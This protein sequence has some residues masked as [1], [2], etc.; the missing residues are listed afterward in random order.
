M[1]SASL[2]V[3]N[4]AFRREDVA[5]P[6]DGFGFLVPH[7]EPEFP[8]MG[9]LFADSAFPHHAPDGYRL[10]R[11]FFGGT[12]TPD[13]IARSADELVETA[14]RTLGEVLGVRGEPVLVDVCPYPDAIPQYE[15]P[16]ADRVARIHAAIAPLTGLHLAANYLEGVSINDCIKLGKK[17][18]TSVY[19]KVSG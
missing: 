2:T 17:V 7:N 9:S 10:L 14:C 3:V 11:V 4:L 19:E 16:H 15:L 5:H 18:A 6:L 13:V 1:N 12:R 8:L